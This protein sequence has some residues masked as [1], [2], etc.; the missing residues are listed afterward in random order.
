MLTATKRQ[1]IS[2]CLESHPDVNTSQ[3]E[4]SRQNCMQDFPVSVNCESL[5]LFYVAYQVIAV[6]LSAYDF[7]IN[8][9]LFG[10][11]FSCRHWLDV[12]CLAHIYWHAKSDV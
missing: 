10:D 3:N 4:V 12:C 6:L 1:G 2:Y 8:F 11:E 9:S 5:S 7:D